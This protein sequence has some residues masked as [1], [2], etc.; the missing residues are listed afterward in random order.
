MCLSKIENFE[1]TQSHGWQIFNKNSEGVLY[2]CFFGDKPVPI[3]KW[4]R[5][6]FRIF[7]RSINIDMSAL[8]KYRK[9]YHIFLNEEDAKTFRLNLARDYCIRK[10]RFKKV[11][12]KGFQKIVSGALL[13]R[14]AKVIVCRKRFVESE[15]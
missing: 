5:D 15:L 9:G 7:S 12:V 11:L 1:V 2:S 14:W 13:T 4:Q 6:K 3:G 8:I 10:V